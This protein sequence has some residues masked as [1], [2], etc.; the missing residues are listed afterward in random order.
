MKKPILSDWNVMRII[1]LVL[2]VLAI[3]TSIVQHDVLVGSIG[4]LLVLQAAFNTSCAG[5]D[6]ALPPDKKTT[7][8]QRN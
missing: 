4:G 3:G 5:G 1:R 6:C 7:S 2:G 8:S